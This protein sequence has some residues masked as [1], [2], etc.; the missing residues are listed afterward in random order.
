MYKCYDIDNK[1]SLKQSELNEYYEHE[2]YEL[3]WV[4]TYFFNFLFF[5]LFYINLHPGFVILG[6]LGCPL[7]ML[8]EKYCLLHR[9]HR[10]ERIAKALS[11]TV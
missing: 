1:L 3:G 5:T 8:A 11:E 6:L 7:M 4:Y 2:E 9:S 10:P